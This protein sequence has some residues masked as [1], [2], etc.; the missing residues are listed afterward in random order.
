MPPKP[1]LI[2]QP[3]L[4]FSFC[5]RIHPCSATCLSGVSDVARTRKI[6]LNTLPGSDRS[7]VVHL[8]E[9]KHEA[10]ND[11]SMGYPVAM[12]Q[13]Y[14]SGGTASLCRHSAHA[15][16][17]DMPAFI[18]ARASDGSPRGFFTDHHRRSASCTLLATCVRRNFDRPFERCVNHDFWDHISVCLG[19]EVSADMLTYLGLNFMVIERYRP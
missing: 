11:D 16:H 18:L 10:Q 8:N 14:R 1:L 6:E 19:K 5:P 9:S 7:V 17:T 12:S 3:A 15:P 4:S 13:S 2:S